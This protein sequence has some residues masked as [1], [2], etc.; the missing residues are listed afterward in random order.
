M[1]ERE[2]FSV[3][4]QNKMMLSA[5]TRLGLKFTGI[6]EKEW[7]PIQ[8]FYYYAPFFSAVKSFVD[9]VRYLFT[10]PGVKAFLSEWIFLEKFFGLR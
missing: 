3:A 6:V 7:E 4:E 5:E 2:G 8:L 10:L 9:L 1:Q